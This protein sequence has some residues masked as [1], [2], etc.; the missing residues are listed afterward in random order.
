MYTKDNHV[1]S[2][3][4]S[5]IMQKKANGVVCERLRGNFR[6]SA[7]RLMTVGFAQDGRKMRMSSVADGDKLNKQL[8]QKKT[9]TTRL[10]PQTQWTA[11]LHSVTTIVL[12]V[13]GNSAPPDQ[14][15]ELILEET[16]KNTGQK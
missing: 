3:K 16:R 7:T 13:E 1:N 8:R 4:P 15:Y 6:N 9:L 10:A 5:F 14:V 12:T 2:A 11:L